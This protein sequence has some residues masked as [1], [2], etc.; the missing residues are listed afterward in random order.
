MTS[1]GA[2]SRMVHYLFTFSM[3][4]STLECIE[5]LDGEY[6]D[7]QHSLYQPLRDVSSTLT[8]M[9]PTRVLLLCL[10]LDL[11]L[12]RVK[13]GGSELSS[14]AVCLCARLL[15]SGGGVN[16]SPARR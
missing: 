14:T 13:E 2:F 3:V 15:L 12:D 9:S 6:N 1:S 4:L 5:L 7:C 10:P 8:R 11:Q 16:P